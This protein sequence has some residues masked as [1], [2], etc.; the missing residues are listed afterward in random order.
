MIMGC[1]ICSSM[2]RSQWIAIQSLL[3]KK[4]MFRFVFYKSVEKSGIVN[5]EGIKGKEHATIQF[6]RLPID[7][8]NQA[9]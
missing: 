9:N 7:S 4:V 8:S 5:C 6:C 3:K 2:Y 1:V